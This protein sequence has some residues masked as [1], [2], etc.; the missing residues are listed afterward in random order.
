M[1]TKKPTSEKQAYTKMAHMC[2]QREYCKYDIGRKLQP[3]GLSEEAISRIV[4]QLEKEK[5]IDER[6]YV[7]SFINDKL[8]F[9]KWGKNKI[10]FALRQKGIGSEIMNEAFA[11]LPEKAMNES[12][13]PLLEKKARTIKAASDYERRTKLIR[14]ALGKGFEMDEILKTLALPTFQFSADEF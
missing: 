6:R 2:A 10:V 4:L 14:F 9:S 1:E 5:F 12:L 13:K 11:E 8:H 7:R 3:M